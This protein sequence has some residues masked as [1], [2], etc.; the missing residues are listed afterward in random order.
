MDD[1]HINRIK[2]YLDCLLKHN[3]IDQPVAD[4]LDSIIVLLREK[5]EEIDDLRVCVDA[6]LDRVPTSD[7]LGIRESGQYPFFRVNPS[8]VPSLKEVN[9]I[10]E[11]LQNL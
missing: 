7:K 5:N 9:Q 11:M 2:E 6:L 3:K 1:K 10:K 4:I 8:Q